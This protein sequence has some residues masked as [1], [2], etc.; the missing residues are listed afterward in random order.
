MTH[1]FYY[2]NWDQIYSDLKSDGLS[3]G[4]AANEATEFVMR[5]RP[6]LPKPEPRR[7]R[8]NRTGEPTCECVDW[9]CVKRGECK[10]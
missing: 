10:R 1:R 4:D 7:G 2:K 5:V 8:C 3:P 6:T 9:D